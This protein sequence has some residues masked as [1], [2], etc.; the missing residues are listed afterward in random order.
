MGHYSRLAQR[1][2]ATPPEW[3]KTCSEVGQLVNSWSGRSD[4]AVY[5][6]KDAVDG[7]A[8]AAFYIKTAEVEINLDKA[9]GS[10]TT[11]AMVG[12]LTQRVNQFDHAEA[13]GVIYHEAL[14]ARYSE[15]NYEALEAMKPAVNAVFQLL[16]ESRIE[17]KG[18]IQMPSNQLFLRASALNLALEE[19][20]EENLSTLSDIR[21]CA[22]VSLLALARVDAGV[23]KLSDVEAT[24]NQVVSVIGQNL[25]NSLRAIWVE[26]QSLATSEVARGEALAIKWLDLLKE[27]DPEGEAQEGGSGEGE[28]SEGEGEGEGKGKG[29][30]MSDL[31]SDLL[32]ALSE[33][34]DATKMDTASD[35]ADQ[36]TKEEWEE[37]SKTRNQ[38]AKRQNESKRTATKVFSNSSGAGES[39][40]SSRLKEQRTPTGAERASAVKIGQMLE[41]AK[42]RERSV[43]EVKSVEPKGRLNTRVLIQNKA[44]E[45]KGAMTKNPAWTHKS[46]K[47][48]DDPT[49]R[50]GIMVDISGSMSG[51]MEALATTAWVMSEAGR[52]VQAKTAMVYYGSGVFPTLKVGQ[53]LEQV[54]VWTAP[55]GTE[56]FGEAFE[57]LDGALGLTYADG[58]RLLVIVSDGHY[59]SAETERTKEA[60][61]LCKA[62][63]VGVIWITPKSCYG[64]NGK[65][66][67][68]GYGVALE[69]LDEK[70]IASEIGRGAV[71]ALAKASVA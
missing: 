15:W 5:A 34:A 53:K 39:G 49:L 66:L 28:P 7:Q 57:A 26:F 71:E 33:D 37:T 56:K 58:V 54:S 70:D 14:H 12:D 59:T 24:Y 31:L 60:V 25:F 6:G 52:R 4:L 38:E 36:Q 20:T 65:H 23:V 50:M 47:H 67:L 62:N 9:F 2:S 42:Y 48:T 44:L 13:I 19:L 64:G 63:G 22:R 1:K 21:A 8:I 69:G 10:A 17:R 55:D 46:R 3:L 30:G 41:K 40:S 11:P 51:A 32:D 35:L 43:H 16:D 27:A 18:V 29:K 61:R 45:S 68:G